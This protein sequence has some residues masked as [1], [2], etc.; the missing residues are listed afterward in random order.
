[1]T[2]RL[3]ERYDKTIV[4]ELCKQFE[5]DNVMEA[6]R[7]EKIVINMGVG[8]GQSD[9]RMMESAVNELTNITGQKACIRKAKKSISNF[10]LREGSNIAC[11][12]T[13]RGERMYE[14]MDRL[15][16]V[17]VPRIRDFR[18]L[19]PRSFDQFGNYTIGLREQTIF[20]EVNIDT[21]TR[22]RGMNIT[23][24]VKNVTDVEQGRE[25]LKKFGM[26]FRA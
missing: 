14:F 23:F 25:L 16:N 24:V 26:P 18:G 3:R 2:A 7:I 8:D 15:F 1:M 17:A 6:P 9:P 21:V 10:K 11:M 13:L 4:P 22:V 12:V 19:P 20:P 5:L